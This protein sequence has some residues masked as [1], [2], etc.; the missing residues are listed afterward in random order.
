MNNARG[1]RAVREAKKEPEKDA[2]VAMVAIQVK[3][4]RLLLGG[5]ELTLFTLRILQLNL[6]ED[7]ERLYKEC[8]RYDL[9]ANL[10][11]VCTS[12][13]HVLIAGPI[14]TSNLVMQA[15]GRWKDALK[16]CATYDRIHLKTTHFLYA[17]YLEVSMQS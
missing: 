3:L 13:S 14:L 7:A 9:L 12:E 17:K 16:V 6:L 11:M 15:C 8:G 2:Q 5:P 10:Y 4:S 1:A